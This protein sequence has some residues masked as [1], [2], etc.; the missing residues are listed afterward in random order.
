MTEKPPEFKKILIWL[1]PG[2]LG[3]EPR[4]DMEVIRAN[5]AHERYTNIDPH[6]IEGINE[7]LD[8]V[9]KVGAATRKRKP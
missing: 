3:R 9:V 6:D 7:I 2:P 4:W 5:G 8:G 1:N